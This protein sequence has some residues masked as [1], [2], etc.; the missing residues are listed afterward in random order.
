MTPISVRR[1]LALLACALV[2][3]FCLG[4]LNHAL[5]GLALT[6]SAPGLL[7]A[8]AALRLPARTGLAVALLSGL[9]I[10]AQGA[11]AFGRNAFLLGLGFCLLHRFALRLPR[12]SALVGVVAAVFLNL[13]L[14]SVSLLVELGEL[15]HPASAA[16]RLLADLLA[17]QLLTALI[18]PWFLALQARSLELVGA[19]AETRAPRYA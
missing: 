6:F 8:F 2:L 9:L 4:R 3:L 18:G 17:S 7:V 13:A 11:G 10:D 15:P 14:V 16:L 12:E 19:P 1:I 5:S